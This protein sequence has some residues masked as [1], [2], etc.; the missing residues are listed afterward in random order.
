ML[1][2]ACS[3]G[4]ERVKGLHGTSFLGHCC[5]REGIT[6]IGN[7][8]PAVIDHGVV[9]RRRLGACRLV[10]PFIEHF[11]HECRNDVVSKARRRVALFLGHLTVFKHQVN[12]GA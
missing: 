4:D 8:E 2:R 5:Q 7:Q 9:Q 3:L 10:K 6:R 12:H 1:H 11:L